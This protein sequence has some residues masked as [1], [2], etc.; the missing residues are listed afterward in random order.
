VKELLLDLLYASLMVAWWVILSI[1]LELINSVPKET[2]FSFIV[3]SMLALE[4]VQRRRREREV[5][6]DAP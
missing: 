5:R 1:I 4:I 6:K 3:A 2:S